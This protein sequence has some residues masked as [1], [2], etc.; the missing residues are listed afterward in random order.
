L[1]GGRLI[2]FGINA[3]H[4]FIV[5]ALE[6]LEEIA[7]HRDMFDSERDI[8]GEQ[9]GFVCR[10]SKRDSGL[11]DIGAVDLIFDAVSSL[12]GDPQSASQQPLFS[13]R[14]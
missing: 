9:L 11:G 3:L 10:H 1:R 7:P 4:E 2:D 13:L 12:V 6:L 5:Q 8:A 14:Y